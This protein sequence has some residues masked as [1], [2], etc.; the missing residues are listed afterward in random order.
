MDK[1]RIGSI[2]VM[3]LCLG[4]FFFTLIKNKSNI[5]RANEATTASYQ[6]GSF[7]DQGEMWDY[8]HSHSFRLQTTD[9]LSSELLLTVKQFEVFL[10]GEPYS[11]QLE[12]SDFQYV[13]V[14]LSGY[15]MRGKRL[16]MVVQKDSTQCVLVDITDSNNQRLYKA[17]E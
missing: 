15:D 2:I 16:R 6:P 7:K 12:V 8:L 17:V 1:R 13:A 9:S 5:Q 10:N 11:A 4:V 14:G 3:V